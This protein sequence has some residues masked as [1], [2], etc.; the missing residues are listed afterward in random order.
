M[1]AP[2]KRSTTLLHASFGVRE[3]YAH[4]KTAEMRI[5][6]RRRHRWDTDTYQMRAFIAYIPYMCFQPQLIL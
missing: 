3:T 5:Q 6:T 2:K 1:S 4:M